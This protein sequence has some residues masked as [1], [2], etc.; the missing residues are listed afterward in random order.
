MIH[1]IST[2]VLL[3]IHGRP[4]ILNLGVTS[5]VQCAMF[6]LKVVCYV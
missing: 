6:Q 2:R 3:M 4:S 1:D 5:G